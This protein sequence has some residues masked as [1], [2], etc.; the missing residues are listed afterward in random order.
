MSIRTLTDHQQYVREMTACAG[1][2]I[3]F[4]EA[5]VHGALPWK[6]VDE[7]RAVL[8]RYS[9]APLAWAGGRHDWDD[10]RAPIPWPE[11]FLDGLTDAQRSVMEPPYVGTHGLDSVNPLQRPEL[12]DG[13]A[14]TDESEAV[15]ADGGW[16]TVGGAGQREREA[17]RK[18]RL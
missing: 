13:G 12:R 15:Y 10:T 7:R 18:A 9:P 14:L 17:Q 11:T 1:D 6:G 4:P 2:L 8:F 16:R 5:L 3:I